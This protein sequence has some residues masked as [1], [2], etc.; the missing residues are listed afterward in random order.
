MYRYVWNETDATVPEFHGRSR[1]TRINRLHRSDGASAPVWRETK[2]RRHAPTTHTR[3]DR[4]DNRSITLTNSIEKSPES[5]WNNLARFISNRIES[6]VKVGVVF[7]SSGQGCVCPTVPETIVVIFCLMSEFQ[8]S[9]RPPSEFLRI[10]FCF[11]EILK[12][13]GNMVQ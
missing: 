2:W 3:C 11:E 10:Q 8:K 6:S 12:I 4:N 7:A 13:F 9:L 5:S 1:N